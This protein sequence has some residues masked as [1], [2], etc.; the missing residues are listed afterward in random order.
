[1]TREGRSPPMRWPSLSPAAH[2]PLD[3]PCRPNSARAACCRSRASRYAPAAPDGQGARRPGARTR[4]CRRRRGGIG[5]WWE[6]WSLDQFRNVTHGDLAAHQ[7]QFHKTLTRLFSALTTANTFRYQLIKFIIQ[8]S[9][10]PLITNE[11]IRMLRNHK[12]YS[13]N[14]P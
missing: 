11:Y 10:I 6:I 9:T 7:A 8:G 4:C 1:M 12:P 13:L 2:G 3:R 14:P 5:V